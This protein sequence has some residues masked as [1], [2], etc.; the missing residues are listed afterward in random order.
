MSVLIKTV[1]EE[2]LINNL[3]EVKMKKL[4]GDIVETNKPTR[5]NLILL[6]NYVSVKP[7]R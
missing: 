4:V 6:V 7:E 5:R 3:K 1:P 2:S